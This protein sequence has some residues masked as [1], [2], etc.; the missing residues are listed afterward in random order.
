MTETPLSES[1]EIVPLRFATREAWLIAAIDALRPRFAGIGAE[2]PRNI[3]ISVG[4]KPGTAAEN[5]KTGG[6]TYRRRV[7]ADKSSA[8]FISPELSD[9][10]DVLRVLVHELLHVS[11]DCE[12]GHRGT[13][14]KRFRAIGMTGKTTHCDAGE[15]LRLELAML[16]SDLG[17]YP[18]AA[19]SVTRRRMAG[20]PEPE[21][22]REPDGSGPAKQGT[23]N[24]KIM[25]PVEGCGNTARTTRK[26]LDAGLTPICPCSNRQMQEM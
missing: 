4:F 26:W 2:L 1:A 13:F 22:P 12:S 15:T 6:F 3:R 21:A 16:A 14:A 11:D 8:V 10:V 19:L 7:S 23:R 25:C 17:E 9:P 20:E 5:A 24:I 18:H